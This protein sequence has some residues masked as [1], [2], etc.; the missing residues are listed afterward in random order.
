MFFLVY[1]SYKKAKYYN[2]LT[3]TKLTQEINTV[4]PHWFQVSLK[5]KKKFFIITILP[6]FVINPMPRVH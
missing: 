5:V 2:K 6:H 3:N 1:L 4:F